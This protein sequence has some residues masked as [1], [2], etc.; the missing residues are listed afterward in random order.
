LVMTAIARGVFRAARIPV[1][2]YSAGRDIAAKLISEPSTG[3]NLDIAAADQI[4][5]IATAIPTIHARICIPSGRVE[6]GEIGGSHT[7][8]RP[9]VRQFTEAQNFLTRGCKGGSLAVQP[10]WQR[11]TNVWREVTSP[12]GEAK[13]LRSGTAHQNG[14]R[15]AACLRARALPHH[16]RGTNVQARSRYSHRGTR[17]AG[18]CAN[19]TRCPVRPAFSP[20][21][22]STHPICLT[23]ADGGQFLY[24]GIYQVLRS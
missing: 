16:L 19:T 2:S 7:F 5:P 10:R 9:N 17:H 22:S 3:T 12:A 13:R 18:R 8:R 14:I 4:R 1:A 24:A 15:R 11:R 6:L 21:P 23:S 20:A